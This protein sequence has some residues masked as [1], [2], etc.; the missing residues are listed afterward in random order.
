MGIN[1]NNTIFGIYT[2][3][4]LAYYFIHLFNED[5]QLDN[6]TLDATYSNFF[7]ISRPS[8]IYSHGIGPFNSIGDLQK[9]SFNLC[10]TL[11]SQEIVILSVE[12]YNQAVDNVFNSEK[13]LQSL[14]EQGETIHNIDIGKNNIWNRIFT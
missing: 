3:H 14:L 6:E 5:G 1:D 10:Q 4:K 12:K 2:Y 11:K 8:K 7:S 9:Y 13:F